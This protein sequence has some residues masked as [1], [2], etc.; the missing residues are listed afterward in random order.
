LPEAEVK[1]ADGDTKKIEKIKTGDK[2]LATDPETGKTES[3]TVL[4]TIITKDD[5]DFTELTINTGHKT[6]IIVATSHHPFWS[7][8]EHT[9]LDAGDLKPGMTL[10]TDSGQ[11]VKIDLA[12]GFHKRQE[13]RNLTI[14]GLH[15]YYVLAGRTPVLVH[16]ARSCTSGN[17]SVAALG[18]RAHAD[19]SD[20]MDGRAHLGYEGEFTLPSGRRPDGGYTDPATGTRVPIELKPDSRRQIRRGRKELGVYEQEMGVPSGSGQLWVYR[21]GKSGATSYQRIQ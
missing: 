9:W 12:R 2:I 20:V 17:N 8:S 3:R 13:T 19:F 1:L 7:P 15:T 5:K 6:G 18:R 16:N 10:R 4:A 14:D 11:A 21:I